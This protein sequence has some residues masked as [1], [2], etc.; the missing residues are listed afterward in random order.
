MALL[1]RP[2]SSSQ[3]GD[4]RVRA[5]TLSLLLIA[6][7]QSACSSPP[8]G[9]DSPEPASRLYAVTDAARTEDRSSIPSLIAF[10]DSDDPAVRMFSIRTLEQLTGQTLGYDHS[11]PEWERRP[12]VDRWIDWYRSQPGSPPARP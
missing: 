6:A 12:A 5:G 10:L 3:P 9:F 4:P 7:A 1:F 2:P 11:A 8:G